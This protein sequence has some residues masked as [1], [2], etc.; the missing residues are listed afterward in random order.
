MKVKV[1]IY[2]NMRVKEVNIEGMNKVKVVKLLKLLNYSNPYQVVVLVNGKVLTEDDEVSNG[3]L[4]K[5][6]E[7]VSGG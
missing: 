4:V 7:V 5:I 3:D 1:I 6:F 2:P